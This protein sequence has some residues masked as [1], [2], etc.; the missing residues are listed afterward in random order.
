MRLTILVLLCTISFSASAQWW[1]IKKQPRFAPLAEARMAG[2]KFKSSPTQTQLVVKPVRRSPYSLSLAEHSVMKM[3]QHNMRFR[4]YDVASYN[5]SDLAQLYVQDNRLSEAKWF[6]LQ[7]N[8]ISRQQNNTRLTIS[9]LLH[10]AMIKADIGDFTLAQQDLLEA[11]EMA[12]SKGRLIDL[13]EVEKKL[14]YIQH[15]RMSLV[16]AEPQ[17]ADVL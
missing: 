3:A 6:Y 1:R 11:R 5:F 2:F 17:Y 9:N 15:N 8:N 14:S 10:L 13:I 12:A 16:K 4:I 7:S